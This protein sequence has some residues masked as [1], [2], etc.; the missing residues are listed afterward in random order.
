MTP[1]NPEVLRIVFQDAGR[2]G[3]ETRQLGC[4]NGP[5]PPKNIVEKMGATPPTFSSK[6]SGRFPSQPGPDL[7]I[8][9][10]GPLASV[11]TLTDVRERPD[12]CNQTA[13][14]PADRA[15][16]LEAA[17]GTRGRVFLT[18]PPPRPHATTW[19]PNTQS[20][21]PSK[22]DPEIIQDHVFSGNKSV[23]QAK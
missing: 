12:L 23:S 22:A 6:F 17:C 10:G 20:H 9:S 8:I 13:T 15:V 2:A 4:L 7:K 11:L 3:P 14:P 19:H 16:G 5:F 1:W 18:P 21:E